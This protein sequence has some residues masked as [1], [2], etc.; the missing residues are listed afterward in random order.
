MIIQVAERTESAAG[1]GAASVNT[2]RLSS[3]VSAKLRQ[4]SLRRRT[5]ERLPHL[6]SES[7]GIPASMLCAERH[8]TEQKEWRFSLCT[9]CLNIQTGTSEAN[10]SAPTH[11]SSPLLGRRWGSACH[12]WQRRSCTACM[13]HSCP[14]KCV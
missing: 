2:V 13:G 3:V 14:L 7:H 11:L 5:G 6:S 8:S 10:F 1:F 4:Q 12:S 9:S